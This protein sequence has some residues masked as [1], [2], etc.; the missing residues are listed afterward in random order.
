MPRSSSDAPCKIDG[1]KE[2]ARGVTRALFD[3][4]ENSS[5]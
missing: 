3:L 1:T 5:L 4:E 2:K